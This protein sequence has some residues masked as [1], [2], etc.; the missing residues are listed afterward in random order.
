MFRFLAFLSRL[1]FGPFKVVLLKEITP[2]GAPSVFVTIQWTDKLTCFE[3][4]MKRSSL[5][6]S[7]G[8]LSPSRLTAKGIMKNKG[9]ELKI[10]LRGTGIT[11]RTVLIFS[12]PP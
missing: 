1:V 2:F 12:K 6:T 5:H 8:H 4:V 7:N 11:E 10:T 3:Y 9:L